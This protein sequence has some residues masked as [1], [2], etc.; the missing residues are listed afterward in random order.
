MSQ[1]SNTIAASSL[2]KRRRIVPPTQRSWTYLLNDSA[3]TAHTGTSF[4]GTGKSKGKGKGKD[5]GKAAKVKSR[6]SGKGLSKG[7]GKSTSRSKGS[8]TSKGTPFSIA[9]YNVVGTSGMTDKC[10]KMLNSRWGSQRRMGLK[11]NTKPS[12]FYLAFIYLRLNC[13]LFRG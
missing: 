2:L 5:K 9:N 1:H 10:T 11:K 4:H 7:K 3:S 8:G 6:T 13:Y 12:Q